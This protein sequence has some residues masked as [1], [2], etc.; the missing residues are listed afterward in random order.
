[1]EAVYAVLLFLWVM[2]VVTVFSRKLYDWVR[3]LGKPHNVAVYYSRKFIH[4]AAGGLVALLLPML[5]TSP[6]LPAALALV[7]ALLTYIPHRT[8][9]LMEWFQVPDN[10]YEVHFCLM[11][12]LTVALCWLLFGDFWYAVAPIAFMAFGDA[13]TGVVRNLLYGRRTK[14]W[15]GNLAMML[16]SC[17]IGYAIAGAWGALAGLAAS[18]V[19][20]FELGPIDDNVTVPATALIIL[21]AGRALT[22]T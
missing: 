10:V 5:F 17:P 3:S 1:M 19:E 8:G 14:A 18:I 20:H 4:V 6:L 12:G 22:G 11:W 2:L 16:V 21:A 9:R 15:I 13:V 7:L